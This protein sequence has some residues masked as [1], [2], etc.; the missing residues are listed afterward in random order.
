M[1]VRLA[2]IAIV[3]ALATAVLGF[4]VTQRPPAQ[5]DIAAVALRGHAVSAALFFTSLGRWWMLL[6][7]SVAAFGIAMALRANLVPLVVV[8]GTQAVSQAATA[9]VKFAFHRVRPGGFIGDPEADLSFPSGHSV[10]AL[11]FFGGLAVL[12]WHA[13]LPR[14][15]AAVAVAVLAVCVVGIPWSRLALGAHYATDVLGGVLFGGAWLCVA[16]A[17]LLRL[18]ATATR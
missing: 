6:P 18:A 4:L 1:T 7:I 3:L 8:L 17:V 15:L 10:T 9:L 5:L 13:P 16:L 2:S 14:P 11:V 12:A